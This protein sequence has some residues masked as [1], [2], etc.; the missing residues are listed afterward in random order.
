MISHL[1]YNF[2]NFISRKSNFIY[3]LILASAVFALI[4]LFIEMSFGLLEEGSFLKLW[5]NR[6]LKLLEIKRITG[7]Q[8]SQ[9]VNMLYWVFGVAFSGTIIAFLAAKITN[10][11][12]DLKKGLSSVIDTNHYIILGWNSSVFKIFEEIKIA[13]ENQSKPTI[14]CFNGMDNIEMNAKINT[15][16]S[17]QEGLRIITRSGDIYSQHDISRT[18]ISKSKSVIILEDNIISNFNIETT[19]L[20]TAINFKNHN[21]PLIV[22]MDDDSNI[23]ILNE[24]MKN[25]IYPIHKDK[26]ISNIASQSIRNKHITSIVM[27]FLDYDGD[28]IY[29]FPVN[30]LVG[31]TVKQVI[32]MLSNITF[33]GIKTHDDKVILNPDKDYIILGNDLLIVVA[34]DDST[35]F[36]INSISSLNKILNSLEVKVD[37]FATKEKLSIFILGWSKLGQQIIDKTIPFLSDDSDIHFAYRKNLIAA[38]PNIPNQN[39]LNSKLTLLT[40]DENLEIQQILNDQHFDVIIILG[41]DDVQ[42]KEVSDANSLLLNFHVRSIL[43]EQVHE[44]S[45]RIIMQLNDGSKEE[46]IPENKFN[47]LIVS[48]T[49]SSLMISQLADNPKLWHVFEKIFSDEGLKIN[50]SSIFNYSYK[51]QLS[52]LRVIDLILLTLE[53]NQTFIG[54]ILN[55]KLYLNPPKSKEIIMDNSLELVFI[56]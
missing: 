53:K 39:N 6:L 5:W 4:I 49:L 48:D 44:K 56:A 10:F 15:E 38:A 13:N 9:I 1:K 46:L 7:S 18:N 2:E 50:V 8:G 19:I 47:E 34:E 43:T 22:Q 31:K 32:L 37:T 51:I 16:F 12:N 24:I 36:Q 52:E 35:T 28:E 27:D 54:Y 20:A 17:N 29:F 25:Q 3:F 23:P 11:I 45:P 26:L 41:Y 14:L 40:Q 21:I 33:I 30:D 55:D 42:S